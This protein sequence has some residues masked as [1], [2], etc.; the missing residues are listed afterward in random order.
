MIYAVNEL[1]EAVSKT[2]SFIR[3]ADI[4]YNGT[5]PPKT[6]RLVD[7]HDVREYG[8]FLSQMSFEYDNGYKDDGV[9]SGT[10]WL[11]DGS[12]LARREYDGTEWW[13][14]HNIIPPIPEY[15]KFK[16]R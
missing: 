14:H 1:L 6:I 4:V 8:E 10:V 12:W 16:G 2:P 3:C 5:T 15:L 7:C 9:L 13:E 11:L